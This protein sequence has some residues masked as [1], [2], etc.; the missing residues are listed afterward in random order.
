M[1]DGVI[2]GNIGGMGALGDLRKYL[3]KGT[4]NKR[5]AHKRPK[6]LENKS[7]LGS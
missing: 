1:R 5:R 4:D 7:R 6:Q 3:M 2:E